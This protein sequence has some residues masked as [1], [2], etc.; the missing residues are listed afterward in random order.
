M[1]SRVMLE[2]TIPEHLLGAPPIQTIACGA[3]SIGAG[4]VASSVV[5]RLLGRCMDDR[6]TARALEKCMEPYSDV[7]QNMDGL[8][9]LLTKGPV[10]DPKILDAQNPHSLFN[11]LGRIQNSLDEPSPLSPIIR[12]IRDTLRTHVNDTADMK[13]ELLDAIAKVVPATESTY[14]S[15]NTTM[16]NSKELEQGVGSFTKDAGVQTKLDHDFINLESVLCGIQQKLGPDMFESGAM[17]QRFTIFAKTLAENLHEGAFPDKEAHLDLPSTMSSLSE[18]LDAMICAVFKA[19]LGLS[20]KMK[21]VSDRMDAEFENLDEKSDKIAGMQKTIDYRIGEMKKEQGCTHAT[22]TKHVSQVDTSLGNVDARMSKIAETLNILLDRT[23]HL[24]QGKTASTAADPAISLASGT[25]KAGHEDIEVNTVSA[26]Q[27][28]QESMLD[29]RRKALTTELDTGFEQI[30]ETSNTRMQ[31]KDTDSANEAD[32]DE[33]NLDVHPNPDHGAPTALTQE[34]QDIRSMIETGQEERTKLKEQLARTIEL[35]EESQKPTQD[36]ATAEAQDKA[37]TELIKKSAA[38][39]VEYFA[40]KFNIVG[41]LEDSR[42][43]FTLQAE[44]KA[45]TEENE[46]LEAELASV[47][48]E[49]S[50]LTA[51]LKEEVA[52]LK[53]VLSSAKEEAHSENMRAEEVERKLTVTKEELLEMSTQHSMMQDEFDEET[54]ARD[55]AVGYQKEAEQKLE[56]AEKQILEL[57]ASLSTMQEDL[58]KETDGR[59]RALEHQNDA[60][61]MLMEAEAKIQKLDTERQVMQDQFDEETDSRDRAITYQK[62]AEQKLKDAEKKLL[63]VSQER[64]EALANLAHMQD[65]FDAET[66]ARDRAMGYHAEAKRKL[67]ETKAELQHLQGQ[68][69]QLN[70]KLHGENE[71]GFKQKTEHQVDSTEQRQNPVHIDDNMSPGRGTDVNTT[72]ST[73]SS[74]RLVPKP[75]PVK[76]SDPE[77]KVPEECWN[78]GCNEKFDN[79]EQYHSHKNTCNMAHGQHFRCYFCGQIWDQEQ[80]QKHG[81]NQRLFARHTATCAKDAGFDPK[82][83]RYRQVVKE[84]V[85]Q[86]G[87]IPEP[88]VYRPIVIEEL[89]DDEEEEGLTL[90]S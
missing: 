89:T 68:Y 27:E 54:D 57:S 38:A 25:M 35:L 19:T 82:N 9:D 1:D 73:P 66:D 4:A 49:I 20:A 77:R 46:R 14:T 31:G 47:R 21:S 2:G 67:G 55:R 23:S 16:Q 78:D 51:T 42:A 15:D 7:F 85:A 30:M 76:L 17:K 18:V 37:N 72:N 79:M 83:L 45:K 60:E 50:D 71:R 74:A 84:W 69:D 8:I 41:L 36:V 61:Q 88:E 53:G 3:L 63:K 32:D 90:V 12:T 44:L 52:T 26:P 22:V 6:G 80:R 13:K 28:V 43:S 81:N 58:R 11:M 62:K 86:R 24:A 34:I 48:G 64:D 75:H 10:N 65:E 87:G 5:S 59:N 70:K 39:A 29:E 56:E 33:I 40:N